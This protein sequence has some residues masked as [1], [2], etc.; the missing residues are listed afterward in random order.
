MAYQHLGRIK[1]ETMKLYV[2]SSIIALSASIMYADRITLYNHTNEPLS[3]RVYYQKNDHADGSS[4][5]AITT[6]LP[7]NSTSLERPP[8]KMKRVFPPSYYDRNLYAVHQTS[9]L[10]DTVNAY[11]LRTF[12]KVNIGDLQG[13]IFHFARKDGI[14]RGYNDT[15]WKIVQPTLQGLNLAAKEIERYTVEQ[16][17]DYVKDNY[18]AATN[19]PHKQDKA[20]VQTNNTLS[21]AEH[22]YLAQRMPKVKKALETFLQTSLDNQYIP[23]IACVFS[24]GGHRAMV[25]TIG[26][27][28]ACQQLG[29]MPAITWNVGLSGSTWALASWLVSELPINNFSDRLFTSIG[30]H[31]T[32]ITLEETQL[33]TDALVVKW[34]YS[35]PLTLVD[36]YGALLANRLFSYKGNGRQRIYLSEQKNTLQ[37]REL[38]LPIFTAIQTGTNDPSPRWYEFSCYQIG[39][40]ELHMYVEPWAF[41]RKFLKG[42][43]KDYAPEQTLGFLLGMFG[44]AFAAPYE[45]IYEQLQA[46]AK[47]LISK[48]ILSMIAGTL[49]AMHGET[50]GKQRAVLSWAEVYNF[51]LG[52]PASLIS[53]QNT[54][55]LSDAGINFNLPYPPISGERPERK[56]D[57]ILLFD[58]S[59]GIH[60]ASALHGVANYAQRKHLPFPEINYTNITK[61]ALTVFQ[62]KKD[63]NVPVVIYLPLIKDTFLWQ[64][65]SQNPQ[66][67]YYLKLLDGFDPVTCTEESFCSTTN[68]E[69]PEQQAR[70]LAA[71]TTFTLLA[72][73]DQLIDTIKNYIQRKSAKK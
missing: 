4:T 50:I 1:G 36:L 15:E 29:L 2:L 10:A 12:A 38:P 72:C 61:R 13:T 64:S 14:I 73:K 24:G 54:I 11:T 46:G 62:D 47:D 48:Q 52:L 22:Q 58:Y 30:Q 57:I 39:S 53:N 18:K 69:Y 20:H 32:K 27:L 63:L 16:L 5:T 19:N 67:R 23:K 33:I 31:I 43:S 71:H 25:S 9:M 35:Q 49:V 28:L 55:R 3:L 66:F 8:R 42:S 68:F 40:P 59:G 37:Q 26:S 60:T 44:S 34:A 21:A 70:Q 65:H 41:G 17:R 7:K 51:T 6:V 45:Q 56:A